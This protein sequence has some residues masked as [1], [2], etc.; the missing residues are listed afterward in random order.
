RPLPNRGRHQSIGSGQRRWRRDSGR[1][2]FRRKR[3]KVALIDSGVAATHSSIKGQVKAGYDVIAKSQEGWEE[4]AIGHGTHCAGI[5]A[6]NAE[7]SEGMRGFA[8][9]AEIVVCKLFP[10]G[11]YSSLLDA[12]DFCIG[13][14]ADVINLS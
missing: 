3:I 2:A 11:R 1:S 6:G 7:N 9:E 14:R 10:G 13:Q 12:L 8:P 4:D 5:I